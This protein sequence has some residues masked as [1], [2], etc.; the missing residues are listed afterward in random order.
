MI[1]DY[2][3][4]DDDYEMN[5]GSG[6][7]FDDDFDIPEVVVIN[8]GKNLGGAYDTINKVV[9]DLNKKLVPKGEKSFSYILLKHGDKIMEVNTF[10]DIYGDG[11][12]LYENNRIEFKN[13]ILSAAKKL[14]LTIREG[15]AL[16]SE[17]NEGEYIFLSEDR[18]FMNYVMHFSKKK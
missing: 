12:K 14:N 7:L 4:L 10:A 15:A 2:D 16:P 3:F 6:S 13:T 5:S 11:K 8:P 9:S 1:D 18:M 17:T